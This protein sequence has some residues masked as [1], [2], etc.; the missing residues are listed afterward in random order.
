MSYIYKISF[1][2]NYSAGAPGEVGP[3]G[4]PGPQGEAGP[5]GMFKYTH[6]YI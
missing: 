3:A 6:K 1:L 5:T 2:F 4:P